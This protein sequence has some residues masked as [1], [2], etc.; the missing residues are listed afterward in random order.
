MATTDT[1]GPVSNTPGG[2]EDDRVGRV[3][4][5]ERRLQGMV[6]DASARVFGGGVVPQE[7]RQAL[8]RE[9]EDNVREQP[10]GYRLVPNSY[11]VLLSPSDSDRAAGDPELN[12]YQLTRFVTQHLT[13][14]GWDTYGEVVVFL[15][16]SDA[17]HTGQF[18]TRSAV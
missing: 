17:L 5:F 11:T 1:I 10:G 12:E 14:Q 2:W 4:R 18:R 7:I 9:A 15:E 13:D 8:L 3:G 6:G 16:R